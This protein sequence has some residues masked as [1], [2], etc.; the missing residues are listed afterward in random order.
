MFCVSSFF[1]E[2]TFI[3]MQCN[4]NL[5]LHF[6]SSVS[7]ISNPFEPLERS[8]HCDP[9]IWAAYTWPIFVYFYLLGLKSSII[10]HWLTAINYFQVIKRQTC[11][12]PKTTCKSR[13][14]SNSFPT[15]HT[16]HPR[17]P[18]GESQHR[19]LLS[20][21][22]AECFQTFLCSSGL[23]IH[24][25]RMVIVLQKQPPAR[26]KKSKKMFWKWKQGLGYVK[27]GRDV[28]GLNDEE[29]N[30]VHRDRIRLWLKGIEYEMFA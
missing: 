25:E 7:A 15:K 4:K 17:V 19:Y 24:L 10:Y 28:P 16:H 14:A 1:R 20:L 23:N 21:N 2:L 22:I 6:D 12:S 18:W 3:V 29:R 13:G 8:S 30:C 5:S 11:N 26:K 27:P 9:W